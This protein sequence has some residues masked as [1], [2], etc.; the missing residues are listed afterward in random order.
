MGSQGKYPGCLAKLLLEYAILRDEIVDDPELM[1][2]YP[3]GETE[4]QQ[5]DWL[6][7]EAHLVFSIMF[8]AFGS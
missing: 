5:I 1:L 7:E 6:E 2:V 4:E 8:R 3:A